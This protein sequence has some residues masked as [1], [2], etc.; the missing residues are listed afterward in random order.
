MKDT[1]PL[2]TVQRK[3]LARNDLAP[4][5]SAYVYAAQLSRAW[6]GLVQRGIAQY[7]ER[8]QGGHVSGIYSEHFPQEVQDSLGQIA[9]HV[10]DA[11]NRA[12][13]RKPRGVHF[14]T[15]RALRQAVHARDGSGFYG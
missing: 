2:T 9:R 5:R 13:S 6:D 3:L 11:S 12:W 14:S 7:G 15:M 4:A 1:Q 10:T 8:P